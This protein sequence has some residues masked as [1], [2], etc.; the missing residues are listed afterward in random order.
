M[1]KVKIAK[2]LENMP[3]KM[4]DHTFPQLVRAI[5]IKHYPQ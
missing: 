2:E 1:K 4:E 5:Y 3:I